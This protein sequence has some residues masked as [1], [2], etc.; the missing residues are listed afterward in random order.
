MDQGKFTIQP[1]RLTLLHQSTSAPNL[2]CFQPSRKSTTSTIAK[3]VFVIIAVG[4]KQ[5]YPS[6]KKTELQKQYGLT[7]LDLEF[8][9][10]AHLQRSKC[11][12]RKNCKSS[13]T[14]YVL[15]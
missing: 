7:H 9:R 4:C 12:V 10:T 15:N 6:C 11:A 13:F 14:C 3:C 5:Y 1:S 8:L 2:I